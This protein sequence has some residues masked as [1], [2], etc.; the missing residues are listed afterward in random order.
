MAKLQ[1]KK[2]GDGIFGALDWTSLS[3]VPIVGSAFAFA[4]EI[5][6]FYSIDIGWFSFFTLAEHVEFALRGMPI[7]IAALIV[8]A[9]LLSTDA[10]KQVAAEPKCT[11]AGSI[12]AT[13]NVQIMTIVFMAC[14][15]ALL[16]FAALLYFRNKEYVKMPAVFVG[17]ASMIMSWYLV[18][19]PHRWL[20]IAWVAMLIAG[21]TYL[22][23]VDGY[24]VLPV[25]ILGL[26][27]GAISYFRMEMP[28]LKLTAAYYITTLMVLT[29]FLGF[30]IAKSW[31][32]ERMVNLN[33]R[34]AITLLDGSSFEGQVIHPGQ[35]GVL[36]YTNGIDA[37]TSGVRLFP[38]N[39]IQ[40]IRLCRDESA[41]QDTFKAPSIS[42]PPYVRV[43]MRRFDKSRRGVFH[44]GLN[45][46]E[47]L[48]GLGGGNISIVSRI[49]A[50]GTTI[51]KFSALSV[52]PGREE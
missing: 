1:K 16:V 33:R 21:A 23:N 47:A 40:G 13:T 15:V 45:G 31:Y 10:N 11:Q 7:A 8:L 18:P 50:A 5:G 29:F 6:Y 24:V 30:V 27:A 19:E 9:I 51:P 37:S 22:N 2:D 34:S 26:I 48:Q 17:W 44:L 3:A 28:S 43:R 12:L 20:R 14:W 52:K 32:F 35:S 39:Q 25:S 4:F 46:S 36:F 41:C 38:L 42:T 49:K